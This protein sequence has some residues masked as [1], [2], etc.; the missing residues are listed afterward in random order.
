[1]AFIDNP[2][3]SALGSSLGLSP[4]FAAAGSP[5]D[6]SGETPAPAPTVKPGV[7]KQNIPPYR[8]RPYIPRNESGSA[9]GVLP[10]G[11]IPSAAPGVMDYDTLQSPEVQKLLGQYGVHPT[12]TPP[13]PNL[14]VHNPEAFVKHPVLAGLLEHGLRGI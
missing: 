10:G 2:I 8:N 11:Q 4:L 9:G 3:I 12:D 1:M 5:T 13:D 7:T 6:S 14:F